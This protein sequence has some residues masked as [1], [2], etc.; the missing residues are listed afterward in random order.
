MTQAIIP[1]RGPEGISIPASVSSVTDVVRYAA[2]LSTSEQTKIVQAFDFN[3]YDMASEFVW[4]RTMSK[5]KNTLSSLGMAFIGEML[6]REDIN[7]LSP[8]ETVLTDY[9]A[10]RL[11]E[12]LG[13]ISQTGAM[14]LR[15]AFESIVHFSNPKTTDEL[16]C[17]EA[18]SIIKNSVQF[19]LGDES[20]YVPLDFKQIRDRL[21]SVPI[22][23]TDPQVQQLISSPT[24]YIST[25]LRVILS[26]IKM[27]DDA[28]LENTLANLNSILPFIWERVTEEDRFLVGRTYAQV[29]SI[30][31]TTAIAGLKNALIKVKGFDYVPENLRSGTYNK[32]AQAVIDAHF[33]FSNYYAE[34]APTRRLSQ[35]GTSIPRSALPKCIQALLCV[36]LGNRYGFS[37]EA[38]PIAEAQLKSI[39][40]DRWQYYFDKVLHSDEIILYK[41]LDNNP[42]Q[43]FYQL[44]DSMGLCS[45]I[46][47]HPLVNK[48]FHAACTGRNDA[49]IEQ[50]VLAMLQK[51]GKG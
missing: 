19:V 15:H 37:F 41:L 51:M 6:N 18:L 35:L 31:K 43:R 14:K 49:A 5:L 33:S 17:I 9:D 25:A 1:W 40:Q 21:T 39:T 11:A 36:Y 4:R 48:L 22:D 32:I 2:Q 30:G 38:A 8:I 12:S 34:P 47:Q 42:R 45:I 50:A 27:F 23:L 10:I 28:R 20:T 13:V 16:D 29:S 7:D 46:P 44:L 24:F 26:A 3:S